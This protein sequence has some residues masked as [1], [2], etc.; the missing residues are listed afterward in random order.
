[1]RELVFEV[2]LR[3]IKPALAAVTALVVW[4]FAVGP[5]GATGSPELGLLCFITGGVVVLLVQEG[6]I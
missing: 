1:M 2:L 5:G 3:L 4:L 6:P